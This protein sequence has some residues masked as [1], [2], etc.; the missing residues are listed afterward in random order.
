MKLS[1]IKTEDIQT[2]SA[3]VVGVATLGYK[4]YG[5]FQKYQADN[6]DL[7]IEQFVSEITR[8]KEIPTDW[9]K[10]YPEDAAT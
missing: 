2:V 1:D 6:A 8:I 4:L 5:V 3:L 9:E 7:T 10:I